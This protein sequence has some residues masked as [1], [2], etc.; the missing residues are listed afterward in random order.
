M[1]VL[2]SI[3][4]TRN[5]IKIMASCICFENDDDD[6]FSMLSS[7]RKSLLFQ[8]AARHSAPP[9]RLSSDIRSLIYLKIDFML[10]KKTR[11]IDSF[12]FLFLFSKI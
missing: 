1:I 12:S 4:V 2:P 11:K 5:A 3:I 10:K 9:K 7:T 8:Y 6:G